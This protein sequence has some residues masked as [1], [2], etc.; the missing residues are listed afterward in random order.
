MRWTENLLSVHIVDFS[1]IV[2]RLVLRQ[3]LILDVGLIQVREIKN[4][5]TRPWI[6]SHCG[7][8]SIYGYISKYVNEVNHN[9]SRYHPLDM[10]SVFV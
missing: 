5:A 4:H 8:D 3:V 1:W 2:Q 6:I 10:V 9:L 7:R